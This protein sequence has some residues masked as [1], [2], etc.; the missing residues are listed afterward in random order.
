MF[1]KGRSCGPIAS[2]NGFVPGSTEHVSQHY[3][4]LKAKDD[5]IFHF[6]QLKE[7]KVMKES[8]EA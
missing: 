6:Y 4:Q 3:G 7:K 2:S 8:K 1:A 5:P